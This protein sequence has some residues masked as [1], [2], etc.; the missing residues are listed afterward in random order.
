MVLPGVCREGF[1]EMET[2]ELGLGRV[3]HQMKG[4][5]VSTFQAEQ[6]AHEQAES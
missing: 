4:K 2:T 5:G 3:V 1:P 6:T